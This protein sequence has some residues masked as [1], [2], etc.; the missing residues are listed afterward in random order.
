ML[1]DIETAK[2]AA[3]EILAYLTST[4]TNSV[5]YSYISQAVNK[6]SLMEKPYLAL[7]IDVL[8]EMGIDRPP[9]HTVAEIADSFKTL[10]FARLLFGTGEE[11]T[12]SLDYAINILQ[13]QNLKMP[14]QEKLADNYSLSEKMSVAVMF[15]IAHFAD[16]FLYHDR[17][18]YKAFVMDEA[19]AMLATESGKTLADKV[20]RTGRSLQGG[21]YFITQNATD[22]AGDLAGNIGI[23]FAFRDSDTNKIKNTLSYY[24]LEHTQE[25]IDTI[26]N[27]EN[28]QCLMQDIYGRIGVLSVDVM[29]QHLF[30][31]FDTRP[32][33]SNDEER[34]EKEENLFSELESFSD[35]LEEAAASR[36]DDDNLDED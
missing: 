35:Y 31:C 4:K 6:V 14:K 2:E 18:L 32:P 33:E 28:G 25:N 22:V 29:F 12:I 1:E 11:K 26:K 24:G 36:E 21:A 9:A 19:W 17:S 7:C 27:L 23:K 13:V 10:S 16:K 34:T 20:V 30:D 5:E 3:V 8:Y 15:A